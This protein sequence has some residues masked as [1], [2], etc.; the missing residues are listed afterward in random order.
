MEKNKKNHTNQQTKVVGK[1]YR[2]G[3]TGCGEGNNG[4]MAGRTGVGAAKGQVV[5]ENPGRG[6]GLVAGIR[7]GVEQEPNQQVGRRAQKMG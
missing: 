3:V 1:G 6:E 5:M 7:C 2:R 4:K